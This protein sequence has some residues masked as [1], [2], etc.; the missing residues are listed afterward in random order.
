MRI[1]VRGAKF[2]LILVRVVKFLNSVVRPFTFV[3]LGA[4]VFAHLIN[5]IVAI[6]HLLMMGKRLFIRKSLTS[7]LKF[8]L[9]ALTD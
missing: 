1:Q 5:Q 2:G 3:A 8:D 9:Y 6:I 7:K 4:F